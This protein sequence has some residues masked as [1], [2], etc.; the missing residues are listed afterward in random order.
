MDGEE[1]KRKTLSFTHRQVGGVGLVGLVVA[2]MP[3]LKET[4]V[5]RDEQR[6]AAIEIQYMRKDLQDLKESI[7]SSTIKVL[8]Q[9]KESEKRTVKNEDRLERRIENVE[10]ALR[11]KSNKTN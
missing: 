10:V 5:T 8:D 2:L 7:E 1:K 11:L 4:F 9:I 3:Y 6:L